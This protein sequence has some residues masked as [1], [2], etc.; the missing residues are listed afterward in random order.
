MDLVLYWRELQKLYFSVP[1]Y[2]SG[3]YNSESV[4]TQPVELYNE[5]VFNHMSHLMTT[6][7]KMAFVPSEDKDQ[8]EHPPNL[9][10]HEKIPI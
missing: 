9:I 2:L 3:V 8:P 10:H 7:T 1:Y 6:L 5:N 4:I